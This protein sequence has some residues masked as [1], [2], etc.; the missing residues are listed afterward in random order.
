M[1]PTGG[2]EMQLQNELLI[3]EPSS[4]GAKRTYGVDLIS[5]ALPFGRLWYAEPN[6]IGNAIR[7]RCTAVGPHHAVIRVYDDAG[8]YDR[9]ARAQGQ[10][11]RMVNFPRIKPLFPLKRVADDST[12]IRSGRA[13]LALLA[14]WAG[15]NWNF[16]SR[17]LFSRSSL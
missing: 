3:H 17:R 15:A 16:A 6:A 7:T 8:Q 9:S 2:P 10:F 14:H 12:F 1:L 5:D 11:Q 4:R 13:I